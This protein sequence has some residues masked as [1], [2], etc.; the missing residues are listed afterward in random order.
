MFL[1]KILSIDRTEGKGQTENGVWLRP[2]PTG[3]ALSPQQFCGF[4]LPTQSAAF[5]TL[6][7][8]SGALGG[9]ALFS[10]QARYLGISERFTG[11]C[12]VPV[13]HA[14]SSEGRG[15][16]GEL[17]AENTGSIPVCCFLHLDKQFPLSQPVLSS[18]TLRSV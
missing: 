8:C 18:A 3:A 2:G 7:Q 1:I 11:L 6:G 9:G 15:K 16:N 5:G 14:R 13:S 4:P 17:G 12:T 10:T